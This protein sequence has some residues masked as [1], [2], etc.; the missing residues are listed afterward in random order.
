[1][2]TGKYQH[3]SQQP[4]HSS[5]CSCYWYKE[6]KANKTDHSCCGWLQQFLGAPTASWTLRK[7]QCT[8]VHSMS[9]NAR[10]EPCSGTSWPHR[11][12]TQQK[13]TGRGFRH[14]ER[15]ASFFE[16]CTNKCAHF[17]TLHICSY[18]VTFSC[19]ASPL[20]HFFTSK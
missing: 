19:H 14:C 11:S 7:L 4:A 1:M 17:F 12:T 2:P 5:F 3:C 20:P 10:A 13:T 6:I 15:C 9:C 8:A 16:H 18:T